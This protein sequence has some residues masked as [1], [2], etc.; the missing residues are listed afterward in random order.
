MI[1]VIFHIS[2]NALVDSSWSWWIM[3]GI[4]ANQKRWMHDMMATLELQYVK[5]RSRYLALCTDPEGGDKL[6]HYLRN[7]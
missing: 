4:L 1:D 7:Q 6:F 3:R 5:I 2:Q